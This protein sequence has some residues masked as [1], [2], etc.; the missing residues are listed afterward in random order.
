MPQPSPGEGFC[1]GL[2]ERRLPQRTALTEPC[3]GNGWGW[4]RLLGAAVAADP[5]QVQGAALGR[6]G[7]EMLMWG[8]PREGALGGCSPAPQLVLEL[9]VEFPM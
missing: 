2:G 7:L 9:D 6:K 5:C 3:L 4:H 1:T 8:L